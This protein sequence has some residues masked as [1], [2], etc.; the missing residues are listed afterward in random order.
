MANLPP[1]RGTRGLR[2]GGKTG[3]LFKIIHSG[4]LPEFLNDSATLNL[5]E[6]LTLFNGDDVA[7]SSAFNSAE[8]SSSLTSSSI[9]LM[10]SAPMPTIKKKLSSIN[11]L[12]VSSEIT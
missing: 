5:F 12:Y 4:L 11:C 10:A 2:S 9:V 1:S 8:S 3:S 6:I 7:L